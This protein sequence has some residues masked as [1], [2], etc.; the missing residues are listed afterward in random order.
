VA[1][2]EGRIPDLAAFPDR[3]DA[4]I[5]LAA[6]PGRES[7]PGETLETLR[8]NVLGTLAAAEYARRVSCGVVFTSTCAVYREAAASARLTEDQPLAPRGLNG[9]S[10]L[11]AEEVL[12]AASRLH[13]FP[14][15]VLRLFNVYGP[16]QPRGYLV[17]DVQHAIGAREPIAFRNPGAVLDFIYVDDVCEAIWRAAERMPRSGVRVFNVGTGRGTTG[18]EVARTM[19]RLA[20]ARPEQVD[21]EPPAK[22]K[23]FVVADPS[24]AE[25]ELGWKAGVDLVAGL[26]ATL[27]AGENAS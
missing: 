1:I 20:G 6:R 19:L 27:A 24:A 17:A 10:K 8:A 18:L 9:L 3:C 5:H 21:L 4:L 12:A 22:E 16:G 13:G 11:L 26:T 14:V 15:T 25:R 23:V 7:T 2:Y